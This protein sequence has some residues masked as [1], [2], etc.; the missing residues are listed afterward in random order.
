MPLTVGCLSYSWRLWAAPRR[1]ALK[2]KMARLCPL[3]KYALIVPCWY[4]VD[5]W[6]HSS[7]AQRERAAAMMARGGHLAVLQWARQQQLP[8]P[9]DGWVCAWAARGG[10]LEVLQWAR[11]QQLPCPWDARVCADAAAGGHLAVLQ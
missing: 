2:R 10:H 4:V 9:W 3:L 6:H 8:W 1:E 5:S 7:S 11:Q